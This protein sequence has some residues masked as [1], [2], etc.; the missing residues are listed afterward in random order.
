MG[1]C[2]SVPMGDGTSK[3]KHGRHQAGAAVAPLVH[4]VAFL[5]F[6]HC[7][8]AAVVR[9]VIARVADM[10]AAAESSRDTAVQGM[11]A[12]WSVAPGKKQGKP[13]YYG[14]PTFDARVS[15]MPVSLHDVPEDKW[16]DGSEEAQAYLWTK[17]GAVLVLDARSPDL[18]AAAR[19]AVDCV[20]DAQR[21]LLVMLNNATRTKADA[22]R[23]LE[24][25][26]VG[27]GLDATPLK[28]S[29]WAV[30]IHYVYSPGKQPP[31]AAAAAA[32]DAKQ[33]ASAAA[34]GEEAAVDT[35]AGAV[36]S[37]CCGEGWPS[38]VGKDA[39][40]GGSNAV[41]LK[42][43]DLPAA[44]R[45]GHV[46]TS[47]P[48]PLFFDS[49]PGAVPGAP[50]LCKAS[51]ANS[52]AFIVWFVGGSGGGGGGGCGGGIWCSRACT[53]RAQWLSVT[54]FVQ[55]NTAAQKVWWTCVADA[56]V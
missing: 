49:S 52:V 6:A 13:D 12:A 55:G 26:A 10:R 46:L 41:E 8:K 4:Q 38:T 18:F 17:S 47:F 50:H 23:A 44:L 54:V 53:V 9:H 21:P 2:G 45:G 51:R 34:G 36:H 24:T 15:N 31:G 37:W 42:D 28:T 32:T 35:S 3:K 56:C 33:P 22:L 29:A 20:L 40:E 25:L 5:G 27:F 19:A 1:A 11:V 16:R 39:V 43:A 48:Q 7:G 14:A 30:D